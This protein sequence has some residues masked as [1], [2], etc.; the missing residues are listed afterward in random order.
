MKARALDGAAKSEANVILMKKTSDIGPV[1][2]QLLL[3]TIKFL[4]WL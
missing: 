2:K 3:N 4:L 1:R